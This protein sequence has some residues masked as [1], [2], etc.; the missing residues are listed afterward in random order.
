MRSLQQIREALKDRKITRVAKECGIHSNTLGEIMRNPDA[1][2][3]WKIVQALNDY[4]D[5]KI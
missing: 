3:T 5:K 1:N 4:L 2:P